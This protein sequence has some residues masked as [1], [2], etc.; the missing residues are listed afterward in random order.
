MNG[1]LS[2]NLV[3]LKG[4]D[5]EFEVLACKYLYHTVQLTKLFTTKQSSL[6]GIVRMLKLEP[7]PPSATFFVQSEEN[8]G[9]SECRIMEEQL[10]QNQECKI[11]RSNPVITRQFAMDKSI[12]GLAKHQHF[13]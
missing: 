12:R 3:F 8:S 10:K 5:D 11:N 6:D 4:N 2:G 13:T 7:P 9:M 1:A